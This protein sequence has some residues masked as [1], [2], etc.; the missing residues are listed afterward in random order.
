VLNLRF[1]FRLSCQPFP[2]V[3]ADNLSEP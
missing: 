2:E 3:E 1:L